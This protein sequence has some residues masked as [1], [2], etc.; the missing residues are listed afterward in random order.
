MGRVLD[1]A[2]APG[3]TDLSREVRRQLVEYFDGKRRRFSVPLAFAGT[4]FQ[5]KVGEALLDIRGGEI[6]TYAEVARAVGRPSAV[7]AVGAALE[8]IRWPSWCPAT[9]SFVPTVGSADTV[10]EGGGNAGHRSSK[11]RPLEPSSQDA[12]ATRPK[13]R[14][15]RPNSVS[16]SSRCSR[17]KSGHMT[18]VKW[19]SA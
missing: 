5:R 14:S 8:P 4:E 11:T 1:L 17:A 16:A 3:S 6:R 2:Y 7:R 9:G 12:A 18:G 15:R 13:R 10:A 19:S